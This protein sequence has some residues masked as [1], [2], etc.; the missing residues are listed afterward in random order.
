MQA[1]EPD[2]VGAVGVEVLALPGPVEPHARVR[3]LEA[4]IPD[5]SQQR[6]TRVLAHGP[7]ELNSEPDI[8]QL[9]L[10]RREFRYRE[11][12]PGTRRPSSRWKNDRAGR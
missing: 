2:D 10:L 12:R 9:S 8:G 3:A 1:Q 7:A 6:G 5:M 11:F 4:L